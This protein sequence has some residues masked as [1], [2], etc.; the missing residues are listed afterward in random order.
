SRRR[1]RA[2]PEKPKA[3]DHR[4]DRV[5]KSNVWNSRYE[6]ARVFCS[7]QESMRVY[8]RVIQP[9]EGDKPDA[10]HRQSDCG[11][12]E[13][14]SSQW[15]SVNGFER[16]VPMG[17]VVRGCDRQGAYPEDLGNVSR[18]SERRKQCPETNRSKDE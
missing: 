15:L 10:H 8:N 14:A 5:E 18:K 17:E 2:G 4:R 7:R 12:R 9:L 6:H 3:D 1:K 16:E 13:H 11:T